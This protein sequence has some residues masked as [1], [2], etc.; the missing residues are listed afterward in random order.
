MLSAIIPTKDSERPLVRTLAALVPAAVAGHLREVVITDGDSGDDTARVAEIAGCTLLVSA[1]PLAAR[2]HAAVAAAR[3][4]WLLFLRPGVIPE[5]GWAEEAVRFVERVEQRG[6]SDVA[7]VFR[8]E[9]LSAIDSSFAGQ[10]IA[11]VREA[12]R[13]TPTPEQ[14]LLIS[15]AFYQ[16]LGGHRADAADPEV[17]LLSRFGSRRLVRLSSAIGT[18]GLRMDEWPG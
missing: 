3:S 5:P 10:A 7:A 9:P 16:T 4:D 13:R 1:E 18:S 11:L 17:D 12:L 15:R 8:S 6:R 14:G 2:L